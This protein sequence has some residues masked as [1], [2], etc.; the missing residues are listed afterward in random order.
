M[1]VSCSL[2]VS[3]TDASESVQ[4]EES[5]Q[6]YPFETQTASTAQATARVYEQTDAEHSLAP[7]VPR[8]AFLRD[9][10]VDDEVTVTTV[11]PTPSGSFSD[12]RGLVGPTTREPLTQAT[13]SAKVRL[14]ILL[15]FERVVKC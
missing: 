2:L 8:T 6:H 14:G 1:R 11:E 12:L 3:Q 15:T 9:D 4:Q 13:T 5:H 10:V 7:Y